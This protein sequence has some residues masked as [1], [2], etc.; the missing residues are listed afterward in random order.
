MARVKP[1]HK[2]S[3]YTGDPAEAAALFGTMFPGI[4]NPAFDANH[5]GMAIA[6]LNP[7]MAQYLAQTSR[8]MALDLGWC[9]RADLRELAIMTVNQHFGS[10][11]S[12]RSREAIALA[13][14]ISADQAAALPDWRNSSLFDEEQKLVIEYAQAVMTGTVPAAL[15]ERVKAAFGET[16]AVEFTGVVGFWSFWAMFLNATRPEER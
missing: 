2:A 9:K 5:D 8:F 7:K 11:Y 16:G 1:V 10:T 12:I 13:G 6:A 3:D 15:F 4:E 14:G